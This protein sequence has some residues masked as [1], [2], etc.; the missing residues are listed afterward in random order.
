[1]RGG[2]RAMVFLVT[3][4][5][6][7]CGHH[8][9]PPPASYK[10]LVANGTGYG[11]TYNRTEIKYSLGVPSIEEFITSLFS[12]SHVLDIIFWPS[13]RSRCRAAAD[14]EPLLISCWSREQRSLFNSGPRAGRH[15]PSMQMPTFSPTFKV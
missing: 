8:R 4:I 3:I 10:V 6:P 1:M 15:P 13:R 7:G 11:R 2:G 12:S 5:S 9:H 14:V